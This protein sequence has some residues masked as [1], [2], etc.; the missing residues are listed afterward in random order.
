MQAVAEVNMTNCPS[1]YT[2]YIRFHAQ[3]YKFMTIFGESD[4]KVRHIYIQ[5]C[6]DSPHYETLQNEH[7]CMKEGVKALFDVNFLMAR[8]GLSNR[9]ALSQVS[10]SS[11]QIALDLDTHYI[12]IVYCQA[13]F[14][15][16]VTTETHVCSCRASVA[17]C[18]LLTDLP[19]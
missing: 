14:L 12:R 17:L 6:T 3:F 9:Y 1:H 7:V 18:H 13:L 8:S 4:P 15:C 5:N 19:R 2:D 10:A 16:V 11:E